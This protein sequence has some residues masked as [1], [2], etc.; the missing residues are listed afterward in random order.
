MGDMSDTTTAIR[1]AVARGWCH[2]AN[3]HKA[4]DPDLAEAIVAEVKMAVGTQ[5]SANPTTG[6]VMAAVVGGHEIDP[7]AEPDIVVEEP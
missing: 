6:S 5:I 3:Q 7:V 2:P 4:M 1:E